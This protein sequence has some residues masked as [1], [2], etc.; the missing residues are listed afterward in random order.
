MR[1]GNAERKGLLKT[2]SCE[3]APTVCEGN[4]RRQTHNRAHP[5]TGWFICFAGQ[6]RQNRLKGYKKH[7]TDI[8]HSVR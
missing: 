4:V 8:L 2:G 1:E 5:H 6:T 7:R 3:D